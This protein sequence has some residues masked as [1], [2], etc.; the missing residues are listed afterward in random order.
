MRTINYS[1]PW[2]LN[3]VELL[4]AAFG[5]SGV[6]GDT[7]GKNCD[8]VVCSGHRIALKKDVSETSEQQV[9][10]TFD[11][12]VCAWAFDFQRKLLCAG[13]ASGAVALVGIIDSE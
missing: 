4:I 2:R 6:I 5:R 12:D 3:S 11:A 1:N 7:V 13:L 10:G 8:L 9:L